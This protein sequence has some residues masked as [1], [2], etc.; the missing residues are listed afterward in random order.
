DDAVLEYSMAWAVSRKNA[1]LRDALNTALQQS[2]AK[3]D[4]ILRG[5]HV[6]LVHCSD[7]VVAGD[8]ASHGPYVTPKPAST[9]PSPA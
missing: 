9:A 6:P 8:L 4:Q 5:Y 2:A 7:C 3:I 1:D